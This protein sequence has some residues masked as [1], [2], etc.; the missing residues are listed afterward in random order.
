MFFNNSNIIQEDFQ[1]EQDE[2]NSRKVSSII[3]EENEKFDEDQD[4][5]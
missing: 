1:K 3:Q 4:Q 2:E 5:E